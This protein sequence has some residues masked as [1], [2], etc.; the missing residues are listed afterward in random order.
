[1][2]GPSFPKS[3]VLMVQIRKTRII[4]EDNTRFEFGRCKVRTRFRDT[5]NV[6]TT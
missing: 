4:S 6:R 3:S 5:K 2:V 1:M